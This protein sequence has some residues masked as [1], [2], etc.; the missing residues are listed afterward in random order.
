MHRKTL[1]PVFNELFIVRG[2][3]GTLIAGP[4]EVK[5]LD[6]DAISKDDPLGTLELDLSP[7]GAEGGDDS[8]NPN[9]N[10]NP[11]PKPNP[12]PNPEPNPSPSPSPSTYPCPT[13]Q[14]PSP[15]PSPSPS[16]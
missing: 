3:L 4:L 10:P 9:P 16:P 1:D 15:S 6:S 7:L 5:V 2:V 11:N 12:K 8:P 14:L 13:G